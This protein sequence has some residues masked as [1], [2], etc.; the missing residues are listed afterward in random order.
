MPKFSH[1]FI[2]EKA[3]NRA[4]TLRHEALFVYALFLF[5]LQFSIHYLTEN[6]PGVLGFASNIT[7]QD[8]FNDT[9]Q[10]RIENGLVPLKNNDQLAAAAQKKAQDMFAKGYWAHVAPDG[11]TPWSFVLGSGYDY[12]Y[13]GENLAKDFQNSGDVV[14]AWYASPSHREN[15]LS[16]NYQDIGLAVVNG[17][18]NGFETTLVV[19]MFGAR[20]SSPLLAEAKTTPVNSTPAQAT[21]APQPSTAPEGKTAL[22]PSL[23]TPKRAPGVEIGLAKPQYVTSAPEPTVPEAK[24]LPLVPIVDALKAA[25]SVSFAFG[26]FLFGLFVIDGIIVVRRRHLRLSGHNLA[27]VGILLLLMGVTWY[28]SVGTII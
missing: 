13:A 4:H 28:T 1:F 10:R 15:L 7:A 25:K 2:P 17:V 21:A 3:E 20:I 19:Q 22:G 23:E 6:Y 18:L 14:N 27:H 8:V 12:V 5:F 16:G 11:V 26:F 9:N 24:K